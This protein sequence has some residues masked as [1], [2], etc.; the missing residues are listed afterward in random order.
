MELRVTVRVAASFAATKELPTILWNPEL[1]FRFHKRSPLVHSQTNPVHSTLSY[2]SK[3]HLNIIHPSSRRK[4][5]PRRWMDAFFL[6]GLCALPISSSWHGAYIQKTAAKLLW[7]FTQSGKWWHKYENN[8]L[9]NSITALPK[10][11]IILNWA[12]T[13]EN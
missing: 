1:H 10:E 12:D 7:S 4:E 8:F 11:P 2:L 13:N 3:I 9:T 5:R 6:S